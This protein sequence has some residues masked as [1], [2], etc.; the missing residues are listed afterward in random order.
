MIS[1]LSL[2]NNTKEPRVQFLKI[3]TM[4]VF[5][6][7]FLWRRARHFMSKYSCRC[8]GGSHKSGSTLG[9]KNTSYEAQPCQQLIFQHS[10]K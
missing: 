5:L 8:V 2:K 1:N 10:Y 4:E 6:M 9:D 7:F 3:L